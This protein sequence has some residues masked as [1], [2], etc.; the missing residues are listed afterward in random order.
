MIY[1][2]LFF[3]VT[4]VDPNVQVDSPTVVLITSSNVSK[5]IQIRGCKWFFEIY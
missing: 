3:T 2:P 1:P 5:V 4:E